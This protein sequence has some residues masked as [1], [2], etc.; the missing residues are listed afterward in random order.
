MESC[1]TLLIVG[2]QLPLHRVLPE[3]RPGARRADRHR[4]AS[5]SACATRSRSAWSATARASLDAL[6]PLLERNDDRAFLE[7]GAGAA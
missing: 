6:L 3:A 1:D 5:G 2:S 4:S 7:T